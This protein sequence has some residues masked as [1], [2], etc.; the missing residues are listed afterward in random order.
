MVYKTSANQSYEW[1]GLF[2]TML[3]AKKRYEHLEI[4]KMSVEIAE[5]VCKIAER[6]EKLQMNKFA[7]Y[8]KDRCIRLSNYIAE[9][10][11]I[12]KT[13]NIKRSLT[14]AH[15]IALECENILMILYE[16]QL[17]ES[18]EKDSLLKKIQKLDDKIL[19]YQ[20]E[21]EIKYMLNN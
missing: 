13:Q 21:S 4:W 19:E 15:L 20:Q 6:L 7:D 18:T 16:Q 3:L 8:M 12:H 9:F 5:H 14:N 17:V 10:S 1:I 11:D 2:S